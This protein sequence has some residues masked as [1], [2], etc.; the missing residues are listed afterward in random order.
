M[1]GVYGVLLLFGGVLLKYLELYEVARGVQYAH[2]PS[3]FSLVALYSWPPAFAVAL[4]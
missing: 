2:N 1:Y 4:L 3:L